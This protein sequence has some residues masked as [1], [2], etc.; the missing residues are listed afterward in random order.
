MDKPATIVGRE[1]QWRT[2]QRFLLDEPAAPLR[3][4]LVSGRRRTG[5]TQLLSAACAAV[6][7]L[8]IVCVQDE[9]DRAA[10]T[11][12]GAALAAQVGLP[13]ASG[14][15]ASWEQL[16]RSA[17]DT[18]ARTATAGQAPLVVI[19][20]F[21]YAVAHAPQLP[22]LIQH[23]YDGAQR[24]GR[25]HGR[26]ILCGSALSVMHELLSGAKPLRGRVMMDMRLPALDYRESATLWGIT[27]P[28]LA[29]NVHAAVGGT[30]GYRA[31]IPR[32][33]ATV[34][35]FGEWVQDN[36]LST[37]I[38]VFTHTEVDYLLRE[39]PRINNRALYFDILAAAAQGAST[40][41]KIGAATGRDANAVRYPL[42][43]LESAGYLTRNRDMLRARKPVITVTD[44]IIRFDRLITAPHLGQLGLG[45]TR[46]VWRAAQPTFR[47]NILGTHFE[48]LSREWVQRFAPAALNRPEGFGDIGFA[49]V[50]D[51]P[52][53]A[54][55]E[56]DVL[57]MHG[58]Q[59]TLIG[60]AKATIHRRGVPDL[61][62]LDRIVELLT[63]L[64]YC[65]GDAVRVLFGRTGFT[66]ELEAVAAAQTNTEL[67]DLDR[68]YA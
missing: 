19:D 18:A 38:G 29:L 60:E 23:L 50:Q 51:H 24:D 32:T 21:P 12:F 56:I 31:L 61:D 57:A 53:K 59:V 47:S 62:R 54:K 37:D 26:L 45:R 22:S 64:G 16:L 42:G 58:S 36:L 4:G 10:R 17:L 52:G 67:V 44:P 20:E 34:D 3:I 40:P 43:V 65:A 63:G 2:L 41:T 68:L 66:T 30:P 55:H 7:G 28:A 11:R 8:Y 27:D 48:Q 14:P 25:P 33:P 5:K 49:T 6:G 9:G 15:P 35:Q 46:E 13:P 1:R 39:D